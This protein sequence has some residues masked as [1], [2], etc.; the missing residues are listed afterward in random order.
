MGNDVTTIEKMPLMKEMIMG[1]KE[2]ISS[3]NNNADNVLGKITKIDGNIP[4]LTEKANHNPPS[5]NSLYE[6]LIRIQ[7]RLATIDVK[8]NEAN[9]RLYDQV[10]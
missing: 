3:I 8:L 9:G 2:R 7:E 5:P 10:G 1:L 6:E 4:P